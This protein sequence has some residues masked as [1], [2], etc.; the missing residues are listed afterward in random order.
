MTGSP[1][2]EF[3]RIGGLVFDGMDQADFTGPFEVLSRT[4]HS[5][6]HVIGRDLS[7]VVDLRGLILTPTTTFADSP[8]L[9][10]LLVPGGSGVNPLMEDEATLAYV[11]RQ[12]AHARLIISVCTGAFILGAAGLLQG[13]R[14][15][16][17]WASHQL[18]PHFGAR[19]EK[20]RVVIDG[21]VITAAGVTSGI[22]AALTAVGILRGQRAAE[23]IQLYLEYSPRPPFH[24][25]SPDTAPSEVVTAVSASI[26]TVIEARGVLAK[27]VGK[28]LAESS[29]QPEQ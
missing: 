18:L 2:Q 10:V 24:S 29:R 14:A 11:R 23:E 4:P 28:R 25:G 1:H 27:R 6:F 8:P 21:S 16:T 19:L 12:A 3:L 15:T 20:E 26:R 13:R 5:E 17:H 22:D 7:T 9:D